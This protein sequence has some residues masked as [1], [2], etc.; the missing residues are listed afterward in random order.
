[1][2]MNTIGNKQLV[3]HIFDRLAQGDGKPFL[4]SMAEDI[5]WRVTGTTRWSKTYRGKRAVREELLGP[6]FAQFAGR[7]TNSAQR[8]IAEDDYVVVECRGNVTTKA[9][10]SY[11]NEYC[12]V[13]RFADGKMRELTDYLDTELVTSALS[14]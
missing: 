11:N 14:G 8:I 9:G 1:M 3:A 7:Y 6:L 12:Y 10:K 13:M 5:C 2:T 4:D